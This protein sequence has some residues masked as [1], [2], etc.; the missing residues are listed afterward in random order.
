MVRWNQP[1]DIV[2]AVGGAGGGGVEKVG[3]NGLI[4]SLRALKKKLGKNARMKIAMK[5]MCSEVECVRFE[6]IEM[7]DI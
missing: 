7:I 6:G 4:E 2:A 3:R 1:V 5:R